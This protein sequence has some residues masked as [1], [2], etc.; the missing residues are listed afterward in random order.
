[1]SEQTS[2]RAVQ[3]SADRSLKNLKPHG[4]PEAIVE[5]VEGS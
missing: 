2:E 3:Y 4:E 1:M 5:K